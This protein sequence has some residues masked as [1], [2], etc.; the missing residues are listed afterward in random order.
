[1]SEADD[2]DRR[3][4]NNE[5]LSEVLRHIEHE[6]LRR[7]AAG[8]WFLGARFS[9]VDVQFAPFL[10]RFDMYVQLAGAALPA[11]CERLHS[12]MESLRKRP[13]IAATAHDTAYH[14]EAR[15]Q[16]LVRM[17]TRTST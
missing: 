6:G 2:A 10:E 11:D 17:A 15:R 3:V 1:M 4:A 8:P 14:V 12:W 13:G 7:T 16:M 9:L 5:K